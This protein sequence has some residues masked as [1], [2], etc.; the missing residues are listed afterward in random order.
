MACAFVEN[1]STSYCNPISVRAFPTAAFPSRIFIRFS[2]LFAVYRSFR[3]VRSST[4]RESSPR[5]LV[6]ISM[7]I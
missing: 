2:F 3:R 1:P 5:F 6:S 7:L 4:A